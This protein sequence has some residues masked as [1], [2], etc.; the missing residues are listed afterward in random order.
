MLRWLS[1][2]ATVLGAPSTALS[3]LPELEPHGPPG[4]SAPVPKLAFREEALYPSL[5]V[6]GF[7]LSFVTVHR[8]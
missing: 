8:T 7:R 4:L 1:K 6:Q 3:A 5:Q 2:M